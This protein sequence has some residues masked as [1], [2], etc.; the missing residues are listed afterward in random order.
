MLFNKHAY[1][2]HLLEDGKI[3]VDS[4]TKEEKILTYSTLQL[5]VI[6]I[7]AGFGL[8]YSIFFLHFNI[9]KRNHRQV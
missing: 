7:L 3:P 9:S 1:L 6:G 4:T 2:F 8:L 5:V